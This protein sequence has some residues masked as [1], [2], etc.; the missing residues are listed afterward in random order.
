MA[1]KSSSNSVWLRHSICEKVS[2]FLFAV[3]RSFVEAFRSSWV[4]S[5]KWIINLLLHTF[6]GHCT[7]TTKNS[8]SAIASIP[9]PTKPKLF[10]GVILFGSTIFF[11]FLF[12]FFVVVFVI[13]FSC[14]SLFCRIFVSWVIVVV[15]SSLLL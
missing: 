13:F 10:D 1:K 8:T 3:S 12:T 2:S 7:N 14:V 6:K 9:I 5:L 11:S 4:K 15:Q